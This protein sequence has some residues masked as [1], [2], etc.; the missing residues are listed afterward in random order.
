VVCDEWG[1]AQR[2]EVISYEPLQGG[3]FVGSVEAEHLR[4]FLSDK[5]RLRED[6][7]QALRE[8]A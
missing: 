4:E 5:L 7:V 8:A 3:E 1:Y 6:S 2:A